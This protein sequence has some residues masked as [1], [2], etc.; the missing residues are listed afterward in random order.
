M[1]EGLCGARGRGGHRGCLDTPL[2]TVSG[3][4][5]AGGVTREVDRKREDHF[6]GAAANRSHAAERSR[7]PGLDVSFRAMPATGGFSSWFVGKV[8][9]GKLDQSVW[10]S[11]YELDLGGEKINTEDAD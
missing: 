9:C 2:C 10:K 5:E 7:K 6:I 8:R 3:E 4:G 1:G 11:K